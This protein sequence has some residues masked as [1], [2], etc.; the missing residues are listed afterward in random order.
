MGAV[1]CHLSVLRST[2]D[3]LCLLVLLA[4]QVLVI[5]KKSYGCVIPTFVPSVLKSPGQH[6]CFDVHRQAIQFLVD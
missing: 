3:I 1:R 6:M 2:K 4:S 5:D